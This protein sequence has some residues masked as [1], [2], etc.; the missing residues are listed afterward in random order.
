MKPKLII[1]I[2]SVIL[3]SAC[4]PD[5]PASPTTDVNALY[6]AAAETF[7][8]QLTQTAEALTPTPEANAIE[9]PIP[10]SPTPEITTTPLRLTTP[11]C[12]DAAW[13][14]DVTIPDKYDQLAPGQEF[15]K[16]W[17]VKNTGTCTWSLDYKL[18]YGGYKDPLGGKPTKIGIEVPPGAI[19]QVSITL[20]AP[21]QKGEY[22]SAWRLSNANG[23]P[24]GDFLYVII[25]I[26]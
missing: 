1:A 18:V 19:A 23:F 2:L 3:L 16:T 6:T 24:F 17:E 8:A 26:R 22:L 25:I 9:T 4:G 20:V 13:V 21:R 7:V 10:S 14:D 11:L 5:T 15:I 12:D